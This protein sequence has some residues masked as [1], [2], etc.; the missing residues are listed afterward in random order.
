M[1]AL[2]ER[3]MMNLQRKETTAERRSRELFSLLSWAIIDNIQSKNGTQILLSTPQRQTLHKSSIDESKK[4]HKTDL[5]CR[6]SSICT[7]KHKPETLFV[8]KN[9]INS[10][11]SSTS[12]SLSIIKTKVCYRILLTLHYPKLRHSSSSIASICEI[13]IN[14]LSTSSSDS[15]MSTEED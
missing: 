12:L 6:S 5:L 14:S 15:I 3:P 4:T 13:C 8:G 2:Y 1:S 9:F 11:G 10:K 7:K